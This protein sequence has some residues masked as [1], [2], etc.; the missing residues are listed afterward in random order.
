MHCERAAPINEQMPCD[1]RVRSA[2]ARICEFTATLAKARTSRKSEIFEMHCE[3]RRDALR[4]QGKKREA[5]KESL[6][7][8][9]TQP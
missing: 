9:I 7:S 4:K 3:R 1:S 5:R 2:I 6:C 8:R